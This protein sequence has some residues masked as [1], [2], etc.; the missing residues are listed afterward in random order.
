MKS[1]LSQ[2][3][4]YL[5]GELPGHLRLP[6]LQLQPVLAKEGKPNIDMDLLAERLSEVAVIRPMIPVRSPGH[7]KEIIAGLGDDVDCIIPVS[8]PAYPTEIWNSHPQPLIERALPFIFWSLI[9][10][11]E[12]DFWRWSAVDFLRTLGVDAV[13]VKNHDHGISYLKALAVKKFL[14][15][16]KMVVFGKQNFPWN[17]PVAAHLFTESLGTEFIVREI[18]DYRRIMSTF[19][20]DLVSEVWN[21]RR[22]RYIEATV[23]PEML[24]E[25]VRIYLAIKSILEQE[26]AFGFG[27]NCYGDLIINGGRDVPCLAQTL[28]REDGYIASCD[29]DYVTMMGMAL[30]T[31]FLG[32]PCMMSNMYPLWYEG[33]LREHF[34]GD[35]LLPDARKYPE[36]TWGNYARLGHCAFVGVISPEMDPSGKTVL[37]DW[38]GTWEIKRDGR[39]CGNAGRLAAGEK[40]TG[41]QFKFDGKTLLLANVECAETTEHKGMPHCELTALMKFKDLKGLVENISREHLSFIYGSHIEDLKILAQVLKLNCTVY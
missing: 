28:L 40:M 4:R 26:Q 6:F 36:S 37:N 9:E 24:N 33:A 1:K 18:E 38:G 41:V 30:T 2:T 12:P 34:G 3:H 15:T 20:D 35:P 39:G 10:F 22:H 14:K 21:S 7:W 25:A 27:V 31:L 11:D 5:S 8:I 32:K 17:A 29:G 23:R 19:S 13:L 16:S